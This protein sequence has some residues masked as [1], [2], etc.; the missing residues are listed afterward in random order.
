[1]TFSVILLSVVLHILVLIHWQLNTVGLLESIYFPMAMWNAVCPSP[2]IHRRSGGPAEVD[3]GTELQRNPQDPE[4]YE[5]YGVNRRFIYHT[6]SFGNCE[7][8]VAQSDFISPL[9]LIVTERNSIMQCHNMLSQLSA[10]KAWALASFQG[11]NGAN[12]LNAPVWRTVR[13][14]FVLLIRFERCIGCL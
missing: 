10:Q 2:G 3:R 7:R 5:L 1:M 12:C 14:C 11:H 6:F 13:L 4:L 9:K 8:C